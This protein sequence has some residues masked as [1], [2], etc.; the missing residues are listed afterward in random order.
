MHK[1]HS[2]ACILSS[3]NAIS[4]SFIQPG[5][6]TRIKF[7]LFHESLYLQLFYMARI[8]TYFSALLLDVEDLHLNLTRQSR[9]ED[10]S[11]TAHW[12]Q[13]LNSFG[14]I[15]WLHVIGNLST[16]T[17]RRPYKAVRPALCGLYKPQPVL[18]HVPSSLREAIV[19]FMTF[20]RLSGHPILVEYERLSQMSE[21]SGAGTKYAQ[22]RRHC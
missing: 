4:I 15:K 18:C 12:L 14:G 7:Q 6:P 9:K 8:F 10:N 1:S 17:L 20:R 19:S 16:H 5:A 21:L 2:Q 3:Q 11:Y 22:C 13:L